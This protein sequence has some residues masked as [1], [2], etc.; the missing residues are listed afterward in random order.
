MKKLW[1][2]KKGSS[3]LELEGQGGGIIMGVTRLLLQGLFY[4]KGPNILTG[5]VSFMAIFWKNLTD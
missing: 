1:D 4:T 2:L 5:S 3:N